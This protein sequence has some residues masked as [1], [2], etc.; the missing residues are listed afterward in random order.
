MYKYAVQKHA[1]SYK[2]LCEK[3]NLFPQ[4]IEELLSCIHTPTQHEFYLGNNM[5]VPNEI[6]PVVSDMYCTVRKIRGLMKRL[7]YKRYKICNDKDLSCIPFTDYKKSDYF[8]LIDK[9]QRYLFKHSDMYNL[10]EASLTHT[11]YGM[12]SNHV[13]IKN[14]YTGIP[15]STNLLYVILLKLKH[16]PPL[17]SYF[18]KCQFRMDDFLLNYECLLRTHVIQKTLKELSPQKKREEIIHMLSQITVYDFDTDDYLPI[19]NPFHVNTDLLALE[20]LLLLY[21]NYQYSLN[22]YQRNVDHKRLLQRLLN[23]RKNNVLVLI[24]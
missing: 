5:F 10:I 12:I 9:S 17:F 23:L 14:P 3:H 7:L 4:G 11:T 24:A 15:F 18:V 19:L 21:Y 1:Q 2:E 6:K 16:V 13:A 8:E 20:P 22:P